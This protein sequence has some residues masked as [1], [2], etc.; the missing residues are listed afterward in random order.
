M[1]SE[2]EE[3]ILTEKKPQETLPANVGVL[4]EISFVA[5]E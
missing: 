1:R 2:K 5:H 3:I 4:I